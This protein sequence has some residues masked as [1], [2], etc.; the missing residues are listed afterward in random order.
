MKKDYYDQSLPY[1]EQIIF[2]PK[3]VRPS[4]WNNLLRLG[5][6]KT[7]MYVKKHRIG[8]LNTELA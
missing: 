1:H 7:Q 4:Q 3:Q 8:L 2:R 6:K 5:I